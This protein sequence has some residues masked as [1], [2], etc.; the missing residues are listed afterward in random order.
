MRESTPPSS[1]KGQ[2]LAR[3]DE[4]RSHRPRVVYMRRVLYEPPEISKVATYGEAAAAIA[5]ERTLRDQQGDDFDSEYV[6]SDEASEALPRQPGL[7]LDGDHHVRGLDDGDDLAALGDPQLVHR[8]DGDRR[9]HALALGI[10]LDVRDRLT[11]GVATTL[12]GTLLRALSFNESLLPSREKEPS[13]GD[14][15]GA[16]REPR[17]PR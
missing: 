11:L 12:A 16:G 13:P 6:M 1:L 10:Q 3:L 17:G 9:D 14:Q 4:L 2:E 5:L 7:L 15:T 8:L